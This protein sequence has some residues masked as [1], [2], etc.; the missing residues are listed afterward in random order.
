MCKQASWSIGDTFRLPPRQRLS[1]I[2]FSKIL[3]LTEAEE[4]LCIPNKLKTFEDALSKREKFQ[5]GKLKY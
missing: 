3:T 4:L 1:I 2:F 5:H